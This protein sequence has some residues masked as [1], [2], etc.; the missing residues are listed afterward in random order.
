MTFAIDFDGTIHN[1]TKREVGYK[2]GT[3]YPYAQEALLA[4]HQ[5]GHKIIVHSCNNPKV[6]RN[7]MEYFCIP[8][9]AIWGESPGDYGQKP[10]ADVYIDDKAIR[11]ENNWAEIVTGFGI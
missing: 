8:F 5:A 1:P 11:F 7:W 4:L 9:D 10:I 2:L 3:P 6:I